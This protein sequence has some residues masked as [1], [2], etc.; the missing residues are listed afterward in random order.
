MKNKTLI[1]SST[2]VITLVMISLVSA[3]GI[4]S[5]YWDE[6]PLMLVR[7][8]TKTINLNVQNMV[9]DDDVTVK[10]V[11]VDGSEFSS[12]KEGIYVVEAGTSDTM[13]PLKVTM[14]KDASPGE[15]KQVKVEFKTVS[16]ASG[17]AMG[18]GMTIAF[19]VIAIQEIKGSN[20]TIALVIAIIIAIILWLILKK[21]NKII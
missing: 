12:I 7:G 13:I 20:T 9:D 21:R 2:L 6:N 3:F 5:P 1:I 18:T 8:E 11:L 16:D 17:I 19:D 15:A 14:P 10:A 4:S